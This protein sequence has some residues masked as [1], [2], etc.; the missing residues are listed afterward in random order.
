MSLFIRAV[1]HFLAV[2]L[3]LP[4]SAAWATSAENSI[5]VSPSRIKIAVSLPMAT[6][7]RLQSGASSIRIEGLM[8]TI[9]SHSPSVPFKSYQLLLPPGTRVLNTTF[10]VD[11]L[12]EFRTTLAHPTPMRPISWI[13]R[14]ERPTPS[15]FLPSATTIE[16]HVTHSLQSLHGASLLLLNLFPVAA[17]PSGV[18]SVAYTGTITVELEPTA[19]NLDAPRPLTPTQRAEIATLVDNPEALADR[20]T[21]IETDATYD[22]LILAS[23]N[24][25]AYQGE[26][27]LSKLV[28]NLQMRGLR[29]RVATIEEVTAATA[30]ADTAAKLRNYIR[31]EYQQNGIQFVLL[32]GD[33]DQRAG[34]NTVPSRK[35]FGSVN[36][37]DGTSWSILKENIPADLY[38]GCLDGDFDGNGNGVW[39][40][41]TD[42]PNGGDVDLLCE[43]AVGRVTAETKEHLSNFVLKTIQITTT[44]LSR[45][46]LLA[47]E[48]LFPRQGINGADY[49][50]QLLG[51]VVEHGYETQGYSAPW[52]VDKLADTKNSQWS[53]TAAINALNGSKYLIVNHLGHSNEYYNMRFRN[54]ELGRITNK[55]PFFLYT[56]GCLPS[57]FTIN[58]SIHE[59][60]LRQRT[61]PFAIIGNTTYGLAPEDP[62]PNETKT[63]GAS[64][65]LHRSFTDLLNTQPEMA[66]GRMHQ[67]S[68]ERF[69][70]YAS[71]PEMRWVFW[72]AN[73]FGD[74]AIVLRF[75][76]N[77]R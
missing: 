72:G 61:G 54:S 65:M 46:T 3:L 9:D 30:G 4:A 12:E 6:I 19:Q 44:P 11:T 33:D 40:E 7:D 59:S 53:G 31:A 43:V 35:F 76:P 77:L 37:F 57:R 25:V 55:S 22:Y 2:S 27:D 64:Q 16:R 38:Y 56:Q 32:V 63:P 51:K 45:T 52:T 10:S 71:T 17:D 75:A 24:L 8:N 5:E 47:G 50:E 15:S 39:G 42:G 1:G 67:K 13:S 26:G 41:S 23:K 18:V 34:T 28:A 70:R 68:K 66:L 20:A 58:D 62:A 60:M 69:L 29:A 73:Y 74:P 49:L 48:M 36:A 14:G 21:L